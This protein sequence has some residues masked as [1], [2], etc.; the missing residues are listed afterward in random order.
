[1]KSKLISIFV[2]LISLLCVH[3]FVYATEDDGSSNVTWTDFSK[4]E[5]KVEKT[6]SAVYLSVSNVTKNSESFYS[7]FITA[8][9]TKPSTDLKDTFDNGEALSFT[10][11]E[12]NNITSY[13]ELNQDLYLWIIERQYDSDSKNY[14]YN[15]IVKGKK[16]ERPKYP[17]Y[18][19]VFSA[20]FISRNETQIVFNVPWGDHTR[21][22][23]LKIGKI[24]DV[25]ILNKIANK[26]NDAFQKLLEYSK[27]S[28]GIYNKQVISTKSKTSDSYNSGY[29][30]NSTSDGTLIDLSK[31]L[32]DGSFYFMYAK[33]DDENGKY[34]PVEGITYAEGKLSENYWSLLFLSSLDSWNIPQNPSTT[35]KPTTTTPTSTTKKD[36]TVA[37]TSIPFAGNKALIFAIVVTTLVGLAI[38]GKVQYNK[39][40]DIK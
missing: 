4:A 6:T 1:M 12:L 35:T 9:N 25:T 39:Y 14:K 3:S 31:L 24:D 20:T 26:E 37:K 34:Y 11:P 27:K 29:V 40:K 23:N 2:I 16:L 33:L 10:T 21:K 17:T 7:Y 38:I 18:S 8:T 22:I 19:D 28:N 15:Y 13:V 30:A 36:T 5:Y 32:Q